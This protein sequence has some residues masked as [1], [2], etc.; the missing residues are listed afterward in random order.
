M[1]ESLNV[2]RSSQGLETLMV[3]V[4][5]LNTL[6]QSYQVYGQPSFPNEM[7]TMHVSVIFVVFVPIELTFLQYTVCEHGS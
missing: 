1:I 2:Q 4:N 7:S 3:N 6:K 5:Y